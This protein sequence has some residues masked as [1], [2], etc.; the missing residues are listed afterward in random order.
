MLASPYLPG[1]LWQQIQSVVKAADCFA[2]LDGVN[3]VLIV[4]PKS[5]TTT[6]DATV[7]VSPAT[8]MIG[9]PEFQARQI[10]VRTLFSPSMAIG[11]GTTVLVKS[12]LA[13]AN[14]AKLLLNLV[15]HDLAS[16]M[17]GGPWETTIIG[18]PP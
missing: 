3:K 14:N 1:T 4:W 12:Q 11:P 8:G 17:P 15:T 2:Y 5:A 9:Y 6:P 7:I 16:Q 13:A 10:V 18:S